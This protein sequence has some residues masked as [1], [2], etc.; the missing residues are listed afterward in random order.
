MTVFLKGG[1]GG[2]TG[3][4]RGWGGDR[5][6]NANEFDKEPKCRLKWVAG[7]GEGMAW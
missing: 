3:D 5:S 1:G 7:R 6:K 4:R 2:G